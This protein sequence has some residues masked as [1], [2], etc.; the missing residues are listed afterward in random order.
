M[1]TASRAT[2]ART[3]GR[4]QIQPNPIYSDYELLKD[5]RYRKR[6]S[7]ASSQHWFCFLLFAALTC[8]DFM[9]AHPILDPEA[10]DSDTTTDAPFTVGGSGF[11]G[12]PFTQVS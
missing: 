1:A 10:V 7:S 11:N 2:C 3:A 8:E 12:H 4:G 5:L 9:F 6:E